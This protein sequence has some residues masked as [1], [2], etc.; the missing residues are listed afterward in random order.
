MTKLLEG[1]KTGFEA[2]SCR[3]KAA[4]AR[5]ALRVRISEPPGLHEKPVDSVLERIDAA[6]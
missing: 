1:K 4:P 3:G 6:K 5:P 2:E